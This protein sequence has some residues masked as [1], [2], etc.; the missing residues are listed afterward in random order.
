MRVTLNRRTDTVCIY[1]TEY[2]DA[3]VARQSSLVAHDIRGDFFFD[4][5]K[6]G[7]LL[8]I[9]VKFAASGLPSDF[10]EAAEPA[11]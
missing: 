9:Q 8:G 7:V 11:Q 1:L 4:L 6:R 10:L 3:D 5:D 2:E